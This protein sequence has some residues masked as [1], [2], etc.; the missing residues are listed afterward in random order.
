MKENKKLYRCMTTLTIVVAAIT[1]LSIFVQLCDSEINSH[2]QDVMVRQSDL[3]IPFMIASESLQT[4]NHFQLLDVLNASIII[5]ELDPLEDMLNDN[6]KELRS[7]IRND[8]IT[9]KQFYKGLAD[10]YGKQ[11]TERTKQIQILK[12]AISDKFNNPPTCS[13]FK[14]ILIIGLYLLMAFAFFIMYK[15]RNL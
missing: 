15:L 12:Q 6:I 5:P 10:V 1:I 9:Q 3:I 2:L 7:K 11:Y 13:K 8:T 14:P 4:E